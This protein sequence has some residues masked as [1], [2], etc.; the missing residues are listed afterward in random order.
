[1]KTLKDEY[2]ETVGSCESFDLFLQMAIE[3]YMRGRIA[4][5]KS[6]ISHHFY[7]ASRKQFR[8]VM[9]HINAKCKQ[10]KGC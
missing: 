9:E 5:S 7:R 4:E 10:F 6:E 1:M 3:D 2:L 8:M